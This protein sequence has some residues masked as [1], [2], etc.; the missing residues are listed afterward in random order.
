MVVDLEAALAPPPPPPKI[1]P[2]APA[3]AGIAAAKLIVKKQVYL[4]R[5]R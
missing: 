4:V 5:K 3:I 2:T 1:L